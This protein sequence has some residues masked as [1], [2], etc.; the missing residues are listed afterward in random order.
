[1][2][3][4]GG[5]CGHTSGTSLAKGF[6]LIVPLKGEILRPLHQSVCSLAHKR[7]AA[8][9]PSVLNNTEGNYLI[10]G[11]KSSNAYFNFSL[12]TPT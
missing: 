12:Q 5:G 9:V 6:S 2:S 3:S 8:G 7:A 1:M 11:L 4:C 10:R